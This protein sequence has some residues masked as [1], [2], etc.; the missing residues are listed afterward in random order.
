MQLLVSDFPR[1]RFNHSV[2][3]FD[4]KVSAPDSIDFSVYDPNDPTIPG[5]IRFDRQV[6]RYRPAPLCE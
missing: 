4:F 5:V 1:I 6:R 3:A 2:L